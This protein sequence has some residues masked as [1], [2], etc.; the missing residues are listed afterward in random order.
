MGDPVKIIATATCPGCGREEPAISHQSNSTQPVRY[1][2]PGHWIK[3]EIGPYA[4][5][6]VCSW[7]CALIEAAR[8]VAVGKGRGA[9]KEETKR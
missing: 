3:V 8:Q 4:G 9:F 2:P 5:R 6:Q 7:D 1:Y